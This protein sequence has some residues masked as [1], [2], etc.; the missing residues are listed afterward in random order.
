MTPVVELVYSVKTTA[1][2]REPWRVLVS[3][4]ERD[5]GEALLDTARKRPADAA[6][7]RKYDQLCDVFK[8]VK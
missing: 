4:L 3:L 7:E 5:Y 1:R 8:A 2:L 6:S